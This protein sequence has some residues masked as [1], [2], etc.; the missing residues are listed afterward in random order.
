M[1][2]KDELSFSKPMEL[3]AHEAVLNIYYTASC[4]KKKADEFF[5]PFGL[6][7]RPVQCYDAPGAPERPRRGPEPGSAKRYDARQPCKRNSANRPDG[8][9]GPCRPH[10]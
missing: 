9:V 1:S 2:L 3:P 4:L 10:A 5:R 7:G 8:K 6:T